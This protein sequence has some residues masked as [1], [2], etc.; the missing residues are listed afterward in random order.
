[1]KK[2]NNPIVEEVKEKYS[3]VE[4]MTNIFVKN[5]NAAM[6]GLLISGDAGQGKT[7]AVQ[8]GLIGTAQDKIDYVKGSSITP[9]VMYVKLWQN[10]RAGDILILDDVDIAHKGTTE[11]NT[12]L[13]LF[14][15]ATE[16]TKEDRTLQWARAQRNQMMVDLDV[17]NTFDFQ[18]AIIWITNDTIETLSTKCKSHWNAIS[19]RF[20]QIPVWLNE[21]EKLMYTLYL[22]E[23]VNMLG[24]DCHAKE[25]GYSN[26]I[27]AKTAKYI[28]DNYKFMN[29]ISPRCSVAIADTIDNFPKEW[30]TY[31]DY[32]FVKL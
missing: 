17:P 3:T 8:K 1:M 29:D 13:D 26:S 7:H 9:A 11:R 4:N 10:R 28:R 5:P 31:C 30:K 24:P 25:G 27:I 6:R 18:G 32:Q 19:S 22:V 20:R 21:Q 15:G 16:P 12:I 14:K 23:E 2:K